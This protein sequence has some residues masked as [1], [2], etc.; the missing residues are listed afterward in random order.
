MLALLAFAYSTQADL[1]NHTYWA[2]IPTRPPP[3]LL[4]VAEWTDIGPF[5]SIND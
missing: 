4:Q 2:Y 3:A 1:I 5:V